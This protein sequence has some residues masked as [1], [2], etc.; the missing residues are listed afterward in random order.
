M[1]FDPSQPQDPR[2]EPQPGG[3]A[4]AQQRPMVPSFIPPSVAAAAASPK[5]RGRVS[6]GT[7]GFV[8]AM[9]VAAAGL[10][11]AG[12]RVTAPAATTTRGGNFGANGGNF[13][14]NGANGPTAS[15]GVGRNGNFGGFGGGNIA[16]TGQVSA[17]ADGSITITT[18]GGQNVTVEVPS[19]VTYHAQAGASASDVKVGS[20]VELTVSRPSFRGADASGAPIASQQTTNGGAAGFGLSATDI[21]VLSK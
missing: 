6:A 19:S 13:G 9:V 3:P 10:G 18:S 7:I 21:L 14:G 20:N 12:G 8:V 17:I 2:P 11:F 1:T 4:P 15:G 16:L 5:P